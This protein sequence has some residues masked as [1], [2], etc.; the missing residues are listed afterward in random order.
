[1]NSHATSTSQSRKNWRTKKVSMETDEGPDT[2]PSVK[3][4]KRFHFFTD[5]NQ[6]TGIYATSLPDFLDTLKKVDLQSVEFHFERHDFSKWLREVVG[7]SLLADDFEK[8]G[9]L[10]L[11]GEN[12]RNNLVAITQKRCQEMND[13][14]KTTQ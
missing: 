11:S 3:L 8:Q 5:L 13:A 12:L 6:P 7:D 9:A 14:L 1:M 10:D 4:E 2:L